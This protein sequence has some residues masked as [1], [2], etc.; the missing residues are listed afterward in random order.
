MSAI[1]DDRKARKERIRHAFSKAMDLEKGPFNLEGRGHEPRATLKSNIARILYGLEVPYASVSCGY[2]KCHYYPLRLVKRAAKLL[3]I[4]ASEFISKI[5]RASSGP[6]PRP[7]T[8]TSADGTIHRRISRKQVLQLLTPGTR[9]TQVT[10]SLESCSEPEVVLSQYNDGFF[11][12]H[13]NAFFIRFDEL[14]FDIKR[15]LLTIKNDDI[16]KQYLIETATEVDAQ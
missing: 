4:E 16:I 3:D 12:D 10:R 15:N 7:S 5:S 13:G 1:S 14:F 6:R 8:W 9:L 2:S 11:S